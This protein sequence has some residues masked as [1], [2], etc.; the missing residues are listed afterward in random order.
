M[1]VSRFHQSLSLESPYSKPIVKRVNGGGP[2]AK[3]KV[4]G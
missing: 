3:L 4:N 2:K 1:I